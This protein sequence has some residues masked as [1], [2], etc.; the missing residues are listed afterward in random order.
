[1]RSCLNQ[2]KKKGPDPLVHSDMEVVRSAEVFDVKELTAPSLI[3]PLNGFAFIL[4]INA[5]KIREVKSFAQSQTASRWQ[6][7]NLLCPVLNAFPLFSHSQD[8][9]LGVSRTSNML[10]SAERTM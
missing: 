1:M 4:S 10:K 2:K 8:C 5:L 6:N 7:Q 9:L 3:K